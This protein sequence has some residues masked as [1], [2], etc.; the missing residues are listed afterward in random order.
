MKNRNIPFGYQY[1]NGVITLH[2]AE[3]KT[4]R[5]IF[6]DYQNGSSL[7]QIAKKLNGNGTEYMPGITGWNKARLKRLTEDER[8]LGNAQYPQ[9]IE[10]DTFRRIQEIRSERN[11]QKSLD[12]T[13]DIFQMSTPVLC[14]ECGQPMRRIHDS[15]NRCKE[16]WVCG[17]CKAFI[18]IADE[19]FLQAVTDTLNTVIRNPHLADV[20]QNDAEPLMAVLRAKNEIGQMLDSPSV[21][22]E[23]LKNKIFECAS[24]MYDEIDDTKFIT[25]MLKAAFEKSEPLSVFNRELTDQTVMSITLYADKSTELTLK[26]GQVIRKEHNHATDSNNAEKESPHHCADR[27]GASPSSYR[28]NPQAR[29]SVL[30]CFNQ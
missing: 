18:T 4:V 1:E 27:A 25:K 20:S 21:D 10:T 15:R 30:P 16:K 17:C 6:A 5:R 12:R 23:K 24:L 2:P 11:T 26:N 22:K 3:C 29:C 8:Y 19:D 14:G 13:S 7:L 9:I 28:T